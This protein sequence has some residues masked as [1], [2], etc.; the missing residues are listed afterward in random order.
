MSELSTYDSYELA[1]GPST[2]YPSFEKYPLVMEKH[3]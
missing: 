1:A 3:E 2:E